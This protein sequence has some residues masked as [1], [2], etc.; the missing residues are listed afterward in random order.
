MKKF[1]LVLFLLIMII[2]SIALA[3][4]WN[5]FSWKIFHKKEIVVPTL[6][7]QPTSVNTEEIQQLKKEIEELKNQV[8]P[9]KEASIT[10]TIKKIAPTG[11]IPISKGVDTATTSSKD[12]C[13]NIIGIQSKV[14]DNMFIYGTYN[15][16]LT[17]EEVNIIAEKISE[18]KNKEIESQKSPDPVFSQECEDANNNLRRIQSKIDKI[19]NLS[20]RATAT[21]NEIYPAQSEVR[22]ACGLGISTQKLE[23]TKS[24]HC[25][26]NY[27][28]STASVSCYEN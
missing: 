7:I 8:S 6:T 25:Y 9:T 3:S 16:C 22:I 26:V 11:N 23:P 24:T 28:G 13:P 21:V 18:A 27:Y 12:F 17:A 15:E 2:P 20:D 1:I 14:P 4:W 19:E 5:P 10:P